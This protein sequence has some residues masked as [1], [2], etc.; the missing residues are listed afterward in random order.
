MFGVYV[1][2]VVSI[3]D[4]GPDPQFCL[5]R[6]VIYANYPPYEGKHLIPKYTG[7]PNHFCIQLNTH[8]PVGFHS[9]SGVKGT[10]R[11]PAVHNGRPFMLCSY[12][13]CIAPL[14]VNQTSNFNETR[15]GWMVRKRT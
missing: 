2:R 9:N 3:L 1:F 13:P 5:D 14:P 4:I 8:V 6:L 12:W 10:T 11:L 15:C 7:N